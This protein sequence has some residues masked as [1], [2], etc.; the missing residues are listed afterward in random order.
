MTFG[1]LRH[2]LDEFLANPYCLV[3]VSAAEV[4]I[5]I[6]PGRFL[7]FLR[8]SDIF[9]AGLQSILHQDPEND[10]AWHQ[11]GDDCERP[12]GD[13]ALHVRPRPYLSQFRQY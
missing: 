6:V 13:P 7:G 4:P 11:N 12:F 9:H 8:G 2:F 3:D 10:R 5:N 1:I